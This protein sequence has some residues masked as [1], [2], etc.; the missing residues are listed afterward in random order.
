MT[1]ALI[2]TGATSSFISPRLVKRIQPSLVNYT[3]VHQ[4][5]HQISA[6]QRVF[7]C[8]IIADDVGPIPVQ[9]VE[10]DITGFIL[11][12]DWYNQVKGIYL[13]RKNGG[14]LQFE[15]LNGRRK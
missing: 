9:A 10:Y 6:K 8:F 7:E 12:M 11:G 14:L 2:D 13:P 3:E 15:S 4:P 1:D 5:G